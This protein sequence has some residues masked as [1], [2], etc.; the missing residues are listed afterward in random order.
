M[1]ERFAVIIRRLKLYKP[2]YGQEGRAHTP[3]KSRNTCTQIEWTLSH[4]A[5]FLSTT[6]HRTGRYREAVSAER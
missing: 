3:T 6:K 4:T 1:C 5:I 2:G